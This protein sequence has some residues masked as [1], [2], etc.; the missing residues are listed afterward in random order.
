MGKTIRCLK[1]MDEITSYS[2]HDFKYCKCGNI[3]IDGG[4]EYLR[5]GGLGYDDKSYEI[6][7]NISSQRAEP[8]SLRAIYA[9]GKQLN[10]KLKEIDNEQ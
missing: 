3:F 10:Q 9:E 4:N 1:C 2:V 6:L 7:D 5:F 8:E